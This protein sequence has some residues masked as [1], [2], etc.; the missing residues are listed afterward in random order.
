MKIKK[1]ESKEEL[2]VKCQEDCMVAKKPRA[3]GGGVDCQRDC[4][5]FLRPSWYKSFTY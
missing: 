2:E 3:Y 1:I 5:A 4:T